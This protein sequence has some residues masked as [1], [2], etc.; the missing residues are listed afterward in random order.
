MTSSVNRVLLIGDGVWSRKVNGAIRAPDESWKTE[1]ISART[2]ISMA[3]DSSEFNKML[4]KFELIW[5]TTT[6]QNQIIILKQLQQFKKKVIL[7]KPIVTRENEINVLQKIICDTY[8]QIYLSQPWTFSLLW[9][10]AK[11]ILL[12][13]EGALEIQVERGGILLRPGLP[14]EIDWGPHDLYLLYDYTHDLGVKS[15]GIS[16]TSRI[17][18]EN[19][20]QLRYTLGTV[21]TFEIETG[22]INPR[23]ALWKV[24]SHKKEVLSLNFQTSE[25]VDY[26]GMRTVVSEF[27]GDNPIITM[28]N[29]FN[30]NNIDINWAVILDLYQ[31]LVRRE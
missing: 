27:N 8:N 17:Q 14:P 9:R 20:I 30:E 25:L 19:K 13:V 5:I 16:L 15:S 26:R 29:H 31:D 23:K 11:K 12:T 7:E 3:K 22:Y 21:T 1:V 24:Y 28:L 6:P 4:N 18:K 2:F 10:E